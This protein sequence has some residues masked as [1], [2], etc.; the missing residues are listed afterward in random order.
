MSGIKISNFKKPSTIIVDQAKVDSAYGPRSSILLEKTA[1]SYSKSG[2]TIEI[3]GLSRDALLNGLFVSIPIQVR[4]VGGKAGTQKLLI[5]QYPDQEKLAV[6]GQDGDA[7]LFTG[8]TDNFRSY[9]NVCVRP[10]PFK[11]LRNCTLSVN[12]SSFSTRPDAYYT[13][14]SKLFCD[15]RKEQITGGDYERFP[16]SNS[17]YRDQQG[18]QKGWYE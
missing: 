1:S 13:G 6:M 5:N 8:N 17:G 12:G 3:Q 7:N 16:Y 4:W 15:G 2:F 10:N 9:D 18:Y 11:C 14:M